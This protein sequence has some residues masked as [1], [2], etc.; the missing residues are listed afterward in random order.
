MKFFIVLAAL[1]AVSTASVLYSAPIAYGPT[2]YVPTSRFTQANWAIPT[3]VHTPA[4]IQRQ[5]ITPG[6]TTLHQTAPLIA[7]GQ[8]W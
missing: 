2:A 3:Q 7:T 1:V 5:V 8:I 4:V 6:V